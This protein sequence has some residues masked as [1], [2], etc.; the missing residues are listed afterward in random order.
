MV[1]LTFAQMNLALWL[2]CAVMPCLSAQVASRV[3]TASTEVTVGGTALHLV[4]DAW[5]NLQ[6]GSTAIPRDS[7]AIAPF[8]V[9][10]RVRAATG[11]RLP[12]GLWID[13]AWVFTA[14][15]GWRAAVA[16]DAATSDTIVVGRLW[17]GP[18]WVLKADSVDVV[19]RLDAR[20]EASRYLRAPR[21]RLVRAQ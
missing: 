18:L 2:S 3:R 5:L 15:R 1:S 12:S 7:L 20:G 14:R 11:A 8:R 19:V 6:P 21:V 10:A 17:G 4:V 13:S 16:P 9:I